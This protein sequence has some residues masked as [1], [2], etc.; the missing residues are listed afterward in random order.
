MNDHHFSYLDKKIWYQHKITLEK[1][2]WSK[3]HI[4]QQ[5][6]KNSNIPDNNEKK[7]VPLRNR[8]AV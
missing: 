1:T 3:Y 7:N 2:V 5:H 8:T 6:K 4:I